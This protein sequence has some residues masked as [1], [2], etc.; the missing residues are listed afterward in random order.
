MDFVSEL[1]ESLCRL[2]LVENPELYDVLKGQTGLS[3]IFNREGH[4]CQAITLWKFRGEFI[5]YEKNLSQDI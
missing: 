3:D 5:E 1:Y 2:Y 4:N